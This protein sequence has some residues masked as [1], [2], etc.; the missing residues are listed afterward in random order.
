MW[1]GIV[2]QGANYHSGGA[3]SDVSE[4]QGIS[5]CQL[6]ENRAGEGG[7]QHLLR[8]S[9]VSDTT[10]CFTY[11]SSCGLHSSFIKLMWLAPFCRWGNWDWRL[12]MI[13]L[14]SQ[15][16]SGRSRIKT[17]VCLYTKVCA[18][19]TYIMGWI[20]WELQELVS[21]ATCCQVVPASLPR[22]AFGL[23]I[24]LGESGRV[25]GLEEES[26]KCLC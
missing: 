24:C 9:C 22:P 26:L 16:R 13:C 10:W 14:G 3:I 1:S 23:E 4:A 21:S 18:L 20:A 7:N 11:I 5:S 25:T 12:W 15:L 17:L 8:T 19:S 2:S 6:Q